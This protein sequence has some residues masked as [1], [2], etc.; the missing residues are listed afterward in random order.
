MREIILLE[1]LTGKK[2]IL[3]SQDLSLIL[4]KI[5]DKTH[6]EYIKRINS[7]V[8][9]NVDTDTII[10]AEYDRMKTGLEHIQF[11]FGQSTEDKMREI[12]KRDNLN[13]SIGDFCDQ[14]GTKVD[15]FWYSILHK[16]NWGE[17]IS[18]KLVNKMN[19]YEKEIY[20]NQIAIKP[21]TELAKAVKEKL[22]KIKSRIVKKEPASVGREREQQS[23]KGK[24]NPNLRIVIDE[25]AEEFRK[26]IERDLNTNLL[27]IADKFL[28]KFPS[29]KPTFEEYKN[30]YHNPTTRRWS[31]GDIK[32]SGLIEQVRG[33]EFELKS[34]YKD[35]AAKR[36]NVASYEI[37]KSF[38]SKMYDKLG[39]FL[40]DLGKEFDVEHSGRL[41]TNDIH[42]KFVDGSKFSI[43]NKIVQKFR[44]GNFYHAYPTTFHD[45]YLSNGQ[46][47]GQ[48][49]EYTIKA[50]FLAAQ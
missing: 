33:N 9:F 6:P 17:K 10:K 39:G 2:V 22:E 18:P 28:E 50:A 34:N 31:D 44:D 48:P 8:D 47:I 38:Q 41:D 32:N 5:R 20:E 27:N 14:Y 12:I 46:K 26:V 13:V 3:E 15:D 49:S 35:I 16:L 1:N 7:F 30:E 21:D 24:L 23:I 19:A 25:I 11:D 42:F 4:S 29:G 40:N 45:A 37:I 43:R 36:A